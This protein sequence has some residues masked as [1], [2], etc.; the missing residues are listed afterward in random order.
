MGK[1]SFKAL[2]ERGI[3][4]TPQRAHVW[5]ILVESGEHFT[6]EEI[7]SRASAGLPGLELSTVYRA[8]ETLGEVGLVSESRLPEGP[9]VFEARAAT[10]PHLVCEVCG[11]ISHP[12]PEVRQ[13]IFEV[14]TASS[15]GFEVRDLHV[16]ARGECT[17]CVGQGSKKTGS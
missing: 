15:G 4:V 6:A 3:R 14:L 2:Q 5:E 9:R 12:E 1:G 13:R 17:A 11:G 10:H 7:W 16:V 8:L